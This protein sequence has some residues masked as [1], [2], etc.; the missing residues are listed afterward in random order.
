[1]LGRGEF[2]VG[3]LQPA[4]VHSAD[5]FS[6]LAVGGKPR[7]HCLFQTPAQLGVQLIPGI[8]LLLGHSP[9]SQLGTVHGGVAIL[10]PG[11]LAVLGFI[12]LYK[13]I[14]ES[15]EFFLIVH[16]FLPFLAADGLFH[17]RDQFFQLC[18]A[19]LQIGQMPVQR[20]QPVEGGIV[21]TFPNMGQLHPQRPIIQNVLQPIYLLRAVVP[22]AAGGHPAGL[23]QA[24]LVVPAQSAGGHPR[25][26]RQLLDGIFHVSP[27]F[28]VQCTS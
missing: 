8:K 28:C 1:M 3:S 7:L 22:V 11:L 6:F 5:L 17:R 27:S 18:L 12:L 21:Q 4:A 10:L 25:Q 15:G 20:G 24:D 26:A 2:G 19:G 16:N 23:Q 14:L 13:A 9:Q